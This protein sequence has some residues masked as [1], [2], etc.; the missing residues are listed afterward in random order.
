MDLTDL[1]QEH[2]R[3]FLA[4]TGALLLL[5]VGRGVLSSRFPV[6]E[7]QHANLRTNAA[8]ARSL[9]VKPGHVAALQSETNEL[10]SRLQ[11]LREEMSFQPDPM[12]EIAP[13]TANPQDDC[14]RTIRTMQ[15]ELV[16]EARRRDIG[17]PEKL[18]LQDAAPTDTAEIQRVLRAL[19][20]IYQVVLLAMESEVREIRG[21]QIEPASRSRP[22]SR[23]FL[24]ELRVGFDVVGHENSLRGLLE[25]ILEGP[26][27]GESPYLSMAAP[28]ILEAD[29]NRPGLLRL[30]LTV[31]ALDIS[32]PDQEQG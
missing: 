6:R 31:A 8:L 2:K 5:L 13:G 23:A 9:N 10:R 17:V 11:T 30:R 27:R 14:W 12:F 18:G 26:R 3:F 29:R 25:R 32:A 24:S 1:W 15:Q 16:D 4:V 20:V 7:Q 22:Q 21:I 19:N 28:T